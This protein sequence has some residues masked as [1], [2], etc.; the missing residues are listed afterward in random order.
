MLIFNNADDFK[1]AVCW[2]TSEESTYLLLTVIKQTSISLWIYALVKKE[3][4]LSV[5]VHTNVLAALK[6]LK[7]KDIVSHTSSKSKHHNSNSHLHLIT[8][9]IVSLGRIWIPRTEFHRIPPCVWSRM[10]ALGKSSTLHHSLRRRPPPRLAM[11][12]WEGLHQQ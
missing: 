3:G 7:L 2:T 9:V 11:H 4:I 5:V 6:F 10:M 8:I 12:C 1:D